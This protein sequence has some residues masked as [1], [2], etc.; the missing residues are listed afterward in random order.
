MSHTNGH[1][2]NPFPQEQKKTLLVTKVKQTTL[3][4]ELWHNFMNGPLHN[5]NDTKIKKFKKN[6]S[7]TVYLK[8]NNIYTVQTNLFRCISTVLVVIIL[9]NVMQ[10]VV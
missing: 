9:E 8:F 2:S 5:K 1:F 4:L 7:S 3:L 6:E 10:N